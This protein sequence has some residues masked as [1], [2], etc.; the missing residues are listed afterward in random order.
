[1]D[2]HLSQSIMPVMKRFLQRILI[3]N[4]A[5]LLS[6]CAAAT[7]TATQQPTDGIRLT[8]YFT[9]T[10]TPS[11]TPT[12]EGL[13]TSTPKPTITPTPRVY[14]VKA[15]DLLSGIAYAFGI[16]V[17]ELQSANPKVNAYLLPI[18]TQ[19]IIPP[20]K[21]VT[22]TP[23]PSTPT[24]FAMT[25]GGANCLRSLSGGYHCYALVENQRKAAAENLMAV[26]TLTDVT[27][28]ETVTQTVQLP[29]KILSPGGSLPFYAYF[30]PPIFENA[31][32]GIQLLSATKVSTIDPN[33]FALTINDLQQ[34]INSDGASAL[35]TGSAVL[36]ESAASTSQTTLVAVA[37][38]RSGN[39]VGL[40]RI[41]QENVLKGG[42]QFDFSFE[43][44]SNG[45]G[46]AQV[47]V[48]GEATE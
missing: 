36:T 33:T 9:F 38:D 28:G 48:L 22:V 29:L 8:P 30:A 17:E 43:V 27:N 11:V 24:P 15:G 35:V 46:I 44:Y 26:F 13:P 41:D 47:K 16:T 31:R 23:A 19:L 34:E 32:V 25:L 37:Y 21:N 18:G 40:R 2:K 6:G 4:L 12:P 7:Q 42:D 39:V 20:A 3:L 45:G 14:T 10:L 5:V 1:M